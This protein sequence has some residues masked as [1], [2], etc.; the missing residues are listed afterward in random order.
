MGCCISFKRI[1]TSK[2]GHSDKIVNCVAH[3]YYCSLNFEG[4]IKT[5][6]DYRLVL[7]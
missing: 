7:V 5:E 2:T 1:E 3:L 6:N 4:K